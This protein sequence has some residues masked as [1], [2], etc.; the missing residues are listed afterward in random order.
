MPGRDGAASEV[1]KVVTDRKLPSRIRAMKVC[2]KRDELYLVSV[3]TYT[4]KFGGVGFTVGKWSL[5]AV[6]VKWVVK[7]TWGVTYGVASRV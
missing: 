4:A 6:M 7:V 1:W 5:R 2:S 3:V